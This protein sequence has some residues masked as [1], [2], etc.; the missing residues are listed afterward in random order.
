MRRVRFYR[1]LNVSLTQI[2]KVN[3]DIILVL[4]KIDAADDIPSL[5]KYVQDHTNYAFPVTPISSR[6]GEN[7][8]MLQNEILKLL[9]TKKGYFD[10]EKY[11][12]QV[13]HRK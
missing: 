12:G 1:K 8:S 3:Q 10:G 9:E 11:G 4:N 6:T 5:V 7:M 2:S 13:K